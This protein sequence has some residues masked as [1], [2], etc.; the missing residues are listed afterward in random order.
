M[1]LIL[2]KLEAIE[3]RIIASEGKQRMYNLHKKEYWTVEEFAW[4][5]NAKN[6][7][8]YSYTHKRLIPYHK[9]HGFNL[10]K[11]ED[12]YAFVEKNRLK[13]RDEVGGDIESL[14]VG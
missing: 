1:D 10:F 12:V 6:S 8:I 9:A 2:K 14:M 13:S 3:K 4:F 11:R 7:T 5:L